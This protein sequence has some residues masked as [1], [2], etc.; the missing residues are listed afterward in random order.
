MEKHAKTSCESVNYPFGTIQPYAKGL[1]SMRSCL[2]SSFRSLLVL[3]VLLA[4][5]VVA[6]EPAN[7]AKPGKPAATEKS[8]ASKWPVSSVPDA[9]K[10]PVVTEHS[11]TTGGDTKLTYKAEAGMLPLLKEDGSPRAN[12]FYVA[13]TVPGSDAAA[14]PVMFCFNGGPGAAAVW[15]HLGGLGP[16][17]ALVNEDASLPPPPF[18]LVDNE[19]TVLSVADL[20]F[21]DPVAT[22]YSRAAKGEKQ[23]QFFGKNPDIAAMGEFIRLYTTR[24]KRWRSPKFLCGE[25]YGVFRAAGLVAELQD[26]HGMFLNGLVLVSGLVD[27]G[28]IMPGP[29]NELPYALYLPSFTAVAHAHA[30]LPAELQA[31]RAKA[32]A[33]AEAFA[34]SEYVTAL[35]AGASL[36]EAKRTEVAKK[37]ARLTGLPEKLVL[38]HD[39]RVSPSVFRAKLLADEQLILGRFDA[40]IT[41]RDGDQGANVPRF[42]PSFDAALGP[43]AAAMNAYV[44]EELEFE[45]DLPYRVLTGVGPWPQDQNRYASTAA[46]LG[47]AMSR[48]HHLRVLV[49]TGR[50]DLAVPYLSMR[51]SID[52]LQI[53]SELLKNV[54]Y[55]DYDSGHMMYLHF[56]DLVKLG[57][58]LREFLKVR[59]APFGP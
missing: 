38:D 45:S 31:D 41:G 47:E 48:N 34:S 10:P 16:R 6:D 32:L 52:H 39:L 40:R 20:V 46:D 57:K 27:Y 30:R 9:S 14:R 50:C 51:Y 7:D 18:E 28:T 24:N 2:I 56:P 25:S 42:D 44:R 3:S 23:E 26:R 11:I 54:T 43:L 33:E 29:S 53:D 12:I 1:D 5:A 37:I 36:P 35:Y 15:L 21:I 22:G 13:Y 8:S 58:D 17:R 59:R 55:A 19:H 4:T 49:Q